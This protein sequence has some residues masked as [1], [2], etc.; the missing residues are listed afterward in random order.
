MTTMSFA[1]FSAYCTGKLKE[2][3]KEWKVEVGTNP[4]VYVFPDG[5]IVGTN[6][7]AHEQF[8]PVPGLQLPL[9]MMLPTLLVNVCHEH[10]KMDT[11]AINPEGRYYS[12]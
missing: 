10:L 9:L 12:P 6:V 3:L 7:N 5:R 11:R 2:K 1:I 4:H 8:I